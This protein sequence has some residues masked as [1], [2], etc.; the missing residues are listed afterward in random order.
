MVPTA[1]VVAAVLLVF[2]VFK[3]EPPSAAQVATKKAGCRFVKKTP[4]AKKN[5]YDAA[6]SMTI[7]TTKTYLATAD[8]SCGSFTIQ[9]AAAQAPKN[10]NSF[11]FLA[12]DG[13]YDDQNIFR[14]APGFVIQTGSR[15]PDGSGNVGYKIPD[16]LPTDPYQQGTV[17]V[18]NAGQ[19][20]TG[21]SSF[22]I[23]LSDNGAAQLEGPPYT[24]TTLGQ[25]T[26]GFDT[27]R[28]IAKLGKSD[29]TP[30]A[31]VIIDK[32]TISEQQPAPSTTTPASTTTTS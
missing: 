12:N 3:T 22:F 8:T 6:P 13:Y 15:N 11:I 30:K 5:K 1:A 24:Y 7:D 25:V 31:T 26:D 20:S 32:I 16:E 28:R 21:D 9:L 27:V 4:P 29:Q 17:A 23:V 10:V 19:P 2:V 14:I 18:A